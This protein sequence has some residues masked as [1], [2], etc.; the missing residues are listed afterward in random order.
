MAAGLLTLDRG[1]TSLDGMWHGDP[2]WRKRV[3]PTDRAAVERLLR[4]G[5]PATVAALTVVESGLTEIETALAG[6][7]Q[8]LVAGREL[9]CPLRVSYPDPGG[10]GVDRWVGAFAAHRLYGAAIVV[11]CG[12]M[13]TV[14]LVD[15]EGN[16]LGGA[17]APGPGTLAAALAVAAPALPPVDLAVDLVLPAIDPA[18][19]VAAGAQLGFCGAVDRLCDDLV[20]A[21][22]LLDPTLVIT[23]GHGEVY[24]RHGRPTARHHPDLLHSGLRWLVETHASNS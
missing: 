13:V 20:A 12:T 10:L 8:L 14:N 7:C 9:P 17:I 18:A 1:N 24:C 5:D 23:G 21:A 11:D 3:D 19:A 4:A 6:R 16:F 2:P 22:G 15:A